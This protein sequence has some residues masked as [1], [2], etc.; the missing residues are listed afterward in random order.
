MQQLPLPITELIHQ[1][2]T[3]ASTMPCQPLE[4]VFQDQI[5]LAKL[6]AIQICT[7]GYISPIPPMDAI[8][9]LQFNFAFH[10]SL[11]Y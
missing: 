4:T 1:A 3:L 9:P 8:A 5:D 7:G 2:A 6:C 11:V 10:F